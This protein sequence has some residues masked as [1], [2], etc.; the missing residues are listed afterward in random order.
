MVAAGII[1]LGFFAAYACARNISGMAGREWGEHISGPG[2]F[3]VSYV[4]KNPCGNRMDEKKTQELM[5]KIFDHLSG[6]DAT[7][8]INDLWS[9]S[10]S[11]GLASLGFMGKTEAFRRLPISAKTC[12]TA[13]A[14]E[15]A[16]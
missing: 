9:D 7:A 2:A 8:S 4:V 11:G 1:T 12:G 14:A 15:A 16:S 5:E 10:W 3:M 13:D 6:A